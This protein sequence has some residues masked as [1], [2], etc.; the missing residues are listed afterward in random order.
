MA[1]P[2][3]FFVLSHGIDQGARFAGQAGRQPHGIDEPFHPCQVVGI[4]QVSFHGQGC[5]H[6]HAHRH[7]FTVGDAGDFFHGVAERYGRS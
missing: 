1:S 5:G 3:R 4:Q 2:S 6:H 7:G